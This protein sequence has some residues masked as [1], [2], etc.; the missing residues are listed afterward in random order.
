M[1]YDETDHSRKLGENLVAWALDRFGAIGLDHEIMRVFGNIGIAGD[2]TQ[3]VTPYRASEYH[4]TGARG[5]YVC[6][7]PSRDAGLSRRP[8]TGAPHREREHGGDV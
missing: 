4:T 6:R 2:I 7:E 5:H 3:H 1:F 8:T